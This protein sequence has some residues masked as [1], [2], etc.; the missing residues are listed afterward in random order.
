MF[1]HKQTRE[2]S[3][4]DDSIPLPPYQHL[5]YMYDCTLYLYGLTVPSWRHCPVTDSAS[6]ET[7]ADPEVIGANVYS[8]Y[9]C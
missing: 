7:P 1:A 9:L 3:L 8:P 6:S 5:Q 4:V 2:S